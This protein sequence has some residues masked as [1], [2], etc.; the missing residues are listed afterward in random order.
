MSRPRIGV[1]VTVGMVVRRRSMVV[2]MVAMVV[3]VVILG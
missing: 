3:V 2:K 1:D